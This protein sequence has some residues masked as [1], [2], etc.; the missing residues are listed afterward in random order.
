MDARAH[1]DTTHRTRATPDAQATVDGYRP[2]HETKVRLEPHGPF[3]ALYRA[4]FDDPALG[5]RGDL[6]EADVEVAAAALGGKRRFG[7]PLPGPGRRLSA[8]AP[9]ARRRRY[10]SVV[11]RRLVLAGQT[12]GARAGRLCL[13]R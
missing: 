8:P 4:R 1:L 12:C 10:V 3:E 2:P 13:G 11:R 7:P 5:A 6:F 9:G